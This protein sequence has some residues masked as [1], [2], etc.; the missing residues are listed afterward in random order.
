[1]RLKARRRTGFF[2]GRRSIGIRLVR[3]SVLAA[4]ALMLIALGAWL[5]GS[6]WLG[7]ARSQLDASLRGAPN[8]ITALLAHAPRITIDIK[9]KH[10]QKLADKRAESLRLG[11]LF[12]ADDDLVPA[13]LHL[14]DGDRS[15]GPLAAKLRLKGDIVDPTVGAKWPMRLRI[16]GGET[17]RGMKRF[18]LHD[19]SARNFAGEWVY[20]RALAREGVIALRYEFVGVTINGKDMGIYALEEH[21]DRRLVEHNE[22]R[23]GPIVRFNENT[24]WQEKVHQELPFPG[25]IRSGSGT[26]SSAEVDGFQTTSA[27]SDPALR[28]QFL[29]AAGRL[30][31]FRSGE[32]S[33]SDV[34]DVAVLAR[35][36]AV[37]DLL[38][39]EHGARWHN[40][41]FY[42]DPVTARLQPIGFDG[43][44][45]RESAGICALLEGTWVGRDD[46]PNDRYYARLFADPTFL[47]A[48]VTELARVSQQDYVSGLLTEL[49]DDLQSS[50]AILFKEFPAYDFDPQVLTRNAA[51]IRSVLEPV[52]AMHAYA[53]RIGRTIELEVGAIQ[54][55][56]VELTGIRF[57]DVLVDLG[58]SCV[59]PGR[60]EGRPVRY[61]RVTVEV[62][63][64]V[65]E[66][67]DPI[68]AMQCRHS[69]LG[70]ARDRSE[71]VLPWPRTPPWALT[72]TA[73]P[74]PS[75]L[76][77]WPFLAVDQATGR[78]HVRPG[79][80]VLD[81]DLVIPPGHVLVCGEAT[82]IDLT[83]GAMILSRSPVEFTGT[84]DNPITVRS[85]DGTGQG[86]AVIGAI[87]RS[88][89][90]HVHFAGLAAAERPGWTLTGAVTFYESAVDLDS[91]RFEQMQ[92]EDALNLVRT[93]FRLDRSEFRG[94][95]SD[96]LDVDFCGPG[97]VAE[98]TFL[99]CGNDAID[100]SGSHVEVEDVEIERVGDKAV[101]AGES[102]HVVVRGLRVADTEIAITSKDLSHLE[103]FGPRIARSKIGFCVYQKKP[104]FG[105]STI[106]THGEVLE[107]VE[108][109]FL[110]E[111][112]SKMMRGSRSVP[113]S[114]ANV[115]EI[116][117]GVEFGKSSK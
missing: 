50:V 75:A 64:E 67:P 63:A 54:K 94:V 27:L 28:A 81:R 111:H 4:T 43:N 86:F 93:E 21:F 62:P 12:A 53:R 104:E 41:R 32:L 22:R 25:A 9:H 31:R 48:Y 116:L 52:R 80:H 46:V 11:H 69:I 82:A 16:R 87:G 30:E 36:Y 38:G 57:G 90:G 49:A 76:A 47:R 83:S 72:T 40:A 99:D 110:V 39:A 84:R 26:Y 5:R 106:V 71:P 19:P 6:G 55:L 35:Y 103:L 107:T 23:A 60:V 61:R 113:S 108:M 73:L 33:T 37:T 115:A 88:T 58:E 8:V 10:L 117:Y 15:E 42:F 45:G 109:P 13:S 89:L 70:L 79:N 20:H 24:F 66:T 85:S 95:R 65:P 14:A 74:A 59:L 102:S 2:E 7:T 56:P 92:S 18:S 29:Q 105:P 91:C 97:H 3:W 68:L 101:S 112:G 34:F 17:L 51:Y 96:A 1:M 100:T 78:I 114:R 77:E 98:C 44:A